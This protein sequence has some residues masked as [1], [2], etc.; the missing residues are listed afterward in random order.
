[1]R[2]ER[3]KKELLDK[4]VNEQ[5][6]Y[7][8]N[9]KTLPPEK[10]LEKAYEKVMRDDIVTTIEFS[11]LTEKQLK[12]L[13]KFK[14]PVSA[15]FDEWQKKDDTYMD[16]LIDMVDKFSEKLVKNEEE[17]HKSKKKHEPER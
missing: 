7:I 5:A 8:E 1:M 17:K 14:A 13:L 15:C 12:A 4:A 2:T 6:E 9:L 11:P 3:L 16:R 10:I